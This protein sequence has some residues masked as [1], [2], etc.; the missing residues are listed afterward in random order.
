MKNYEKLK[1]RFR[2]TKTPIHFLRKLLLRIFS[3]FAD[4]KYWIKISMCLILP[5][6]ATKNQKIVLK[7]YSGYCL[8][9]KNSKKSNIR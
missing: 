1:F 8:F 5:K 6:K 4:V 7:K 2:P 9:L 3:S